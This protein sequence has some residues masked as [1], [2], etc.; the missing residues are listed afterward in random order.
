M[1]RPEQMLLYLQI[2]TPPGV[3]P[4]NATLS[5]HEYGRMQ[6]HSDVP[7]RSSLAVA[8]IALDDAER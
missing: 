7:F 1:K 3:K 8:D 4:G 6:L 2:K 5:S